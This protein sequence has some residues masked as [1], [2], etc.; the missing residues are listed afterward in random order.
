MTDVTASDVF[1]ALKGMVGLIQLIQSDRPD[2]Q[3][4]HRFIEAIDVIARVEAKTD[5][6]LSRSRRKL[7][8][9]FLSPSFCELC[10][11]NAPMQGDVYL[12][13]MREDAA[14]HA[15][16]CPYRLLLQAEAEAK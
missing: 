13:D 1:N 15:D 16:E 6:L 11:Q 14:S 4:N 7:A 3:S 8:D 5:T 2:L 10:S 12:Y 9:D